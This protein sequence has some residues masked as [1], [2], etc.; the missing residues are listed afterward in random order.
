LKKIDLLKIDVEGAEGKIIKDLAEKEKLKNTANICLEYHYGLDK[1]NN[2]LAKI[3]FELEKNNFDY[4]INPD[5]LIED[6]IPLSS[7][8]KTRKYVL[9]VNCIKKK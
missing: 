2:S 3:L 9:I 7:F 6:N 4:V 1:Q 5:S 8:K